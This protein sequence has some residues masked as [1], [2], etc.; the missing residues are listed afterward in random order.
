LESYKQ[1][2]RRFVDQLVVADAAA[3]GTPQPL[4]GRNAEIKEMISLLRCASFS[5]N[6]VLSGTNRHRHG[7]LEQTVRR[8]V[9]LLDRL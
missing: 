3:D 5:G 4:G 2:L 9:E 1:K 7:T 6:F 8:F